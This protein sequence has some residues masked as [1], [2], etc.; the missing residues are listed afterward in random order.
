MLLAR[1]NHITRLSPSARPRGKKRRE[2]KDKRVWL[3]RKQWRLQVNLQFSRS[4]YNS[5]LQEGNDIVWFYMKEA[6]NSDGY[7]SSKCL[8]SPV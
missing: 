2:D 1:W 4:I 5:L 6:H 8:S 7:A 3:F